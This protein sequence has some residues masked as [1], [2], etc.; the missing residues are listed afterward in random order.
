[1]RNEIP[2]RFIIASDVLIGEWDWNKKEQCI[3][4]NLPIMDSDTLGRCPE[5]HHAAHLDHFQE[6]LKIKGICPFC[7]RKVKM[8][9][10]LKK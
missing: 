1:M 10:L 3:V 8:K 5:C 9:D 6:W 4:C 2:M 7:K